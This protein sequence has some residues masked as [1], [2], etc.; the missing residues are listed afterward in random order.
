METCLISC[1]DSKCITNTLQVLTKEWMH[2]YCQSRRK[3]VSVSFSL[4]Q[5]P[6]KCHT[7]FFLIS[8]NLSSSFEQ[9]SPTS[10]RKAK[11]MPPPAQ[12]HR[13]KSLPNSPAHLRA[14]KRGVQPHSSVGW[15]LWCLLRLVLKSHHNSFIAVLLLADW[16][17]ALES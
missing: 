12:K 15:L 2:Q 5:N 8:G 17:S 6:T 4:K 1:S 7:G 16:N 11:W 13:T 9:T 10:G 14:E 3:G